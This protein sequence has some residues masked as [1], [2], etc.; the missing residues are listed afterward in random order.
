MTKRCTSDWVFT[1]GT[2]LIDPLN[3]TPDV[4]HLWLPIFNR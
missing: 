4:H 2:M 1:Q 3:R